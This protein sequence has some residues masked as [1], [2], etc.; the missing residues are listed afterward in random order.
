MEYCLLL[1][2]VVCPWPPNITNATII[3][4]GTGL[5][6]VTTYECNPG[7]RTEDGTS[8]RNIS[9]SMFSTWSDDVITCAREL[10]AAS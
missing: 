9:C 10:L 6:D 1:V 8:T 7:L 5:D 3:V 2:E 4:A